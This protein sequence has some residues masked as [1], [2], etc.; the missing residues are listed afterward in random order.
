MQWCLQSISGS[1]LPHWFHWECPS[2][3]DCRRPQERWQWWQPAW[4]WQVANCIHILTSDECIAP[5][6]S[7]QFDCIVPK[8]SLQLHDFKISS[9]TGNSIHDLFYGQCDD[10]MLLS[11][12]L[13]H[14]ERSCT[15]L[16]CNVLPRL[17]L[18]LY[19]CDYPS[20]WS[21]TAWRFDFLCLQLEMPSF[22]HG[23]DQFPSVCTIA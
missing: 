5:E 6:V 4:S 23:P 1:Y 7:I 20:F 19:W 21:R 8:V 2:N 11:L 9:S 14:G 15:W 18:Q 13:I 16:L 17:D 10:A 12:T 22:D 3:Y